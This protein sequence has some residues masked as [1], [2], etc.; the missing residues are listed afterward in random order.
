LHFGQQCCVAQSSGSMVLG[1]CLEPGYASFSNEE[2]ATARAPRGSYSKLKCL[3]CRERKIKCVLPSLSI[4]ASPTPQPSGTSCARCQ[5]QGLECIVD[6]TVLGRPSQKRPR[7]TTGTASNLGY[8]ESEP[9][10]AA[11]DDEEADG[12]V[13]AFVLSHVQSAVDDIDAV[14]SSP[15]KKKPSRHEI[16]AALVDSTHL[17]S[18]LLAQDSSFGS[19]AVP[20]DDTTPV[21]PM[22]LVDED[23]LC[24]MDKQYVGGL[25]L[26]H[27][28]SS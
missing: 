14:E 7:S 4:E 24:A 1:R 23:L 6:K 28:L 17:L 27:Q 10:F 8:G 5:Q 20:K 16:F 12:D 11:E 9:T 2:S 26:E 19:Q 25:P 21:D 15:Q 18:A 3:Q 22:G 13:Q